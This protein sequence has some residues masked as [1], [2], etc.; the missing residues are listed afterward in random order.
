MGGLVRYDG[1][2]AEDCVVMGGGLLLAFASLW[3]GTCWFCERQ[4]WCNSLLNW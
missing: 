3:G 4:C 1:H 2:R